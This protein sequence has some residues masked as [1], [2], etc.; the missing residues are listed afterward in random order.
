MGTLAMI[1]AGHVNP[2]KIENN[3][4]IAYHRSVHQENL[5]A[6][7]LKADSI[8]TIVT[9][10]VS[11]IRSKRLR[12]MEFKDLINKM[13]TGFEDLFTFPKTESQMLTRV[14]NLKEEK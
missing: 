12:H 8:T 4:L 5:C 11:F 2:I 10:V 13:D 14:F 6:K 7:Y 3:S 1:G 9:K